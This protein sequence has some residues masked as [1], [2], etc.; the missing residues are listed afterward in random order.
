MANINEEFELI[1]I[2]LISHGSSGSHLIFKYP[3]VNSD[4]VHE[5]DYK[6]FSKSN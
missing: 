2:M 6:S 4:S 3:F 1:S 5:S